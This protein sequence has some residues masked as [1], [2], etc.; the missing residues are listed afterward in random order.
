MR[1]IYGIDEL[2]FYLYDTTIS[3]IYNDE[4]LKDNIINKLSRNSYY[5]ID[6]KLVNQ[7]VTVSD[8]LKI[9]EFNMKLVP[10]FGLKSIM[11]LKYSSLDFNIRIF[12]K[13]IVLINLI[14]TNIV[15]DDV[16]TFLSDDQKYLILKYLKDNKVNFINF[17]SDIEEVLFTKYLIV[18]NKNGVIIEGNTKS[19][20]REEKI[21]RR[22]GFS[23]PFAVDLSLQL[24]A[25]DVL[26]KE[27]YNLEKLV[28]ELW[29]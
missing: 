21:L 4:K 27:E 18:L 16:L 24:V 6:S 25:Y 26:D 29:K 28:N 5:V 2:K 22:N 10:F 20:L 12:L 1:K 23:L 3:I 8:F 7:N 14:K 15:F 9:N 11:S 19:V 13:I 17:T